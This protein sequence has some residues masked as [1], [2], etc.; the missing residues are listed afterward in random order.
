MKADN[1]MV[2]SEWWTLED[3][4]NRLPNFDSGEF[5]SDMSPDVKERV[6]K[7]HAYLADRI[8]KKNVTLYGVNTGFGSLANTRIPDDKLSELQYKILISHACGVGE[9]VPFE[10]V[11]LIILLKMVIY[12]KLKN[13]QK[14]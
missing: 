14:I 3:V 4:Y 11:R 2:D 8:A 5:I 10:I 7:C 12:Y 1:F 6:E 13:I 9:E